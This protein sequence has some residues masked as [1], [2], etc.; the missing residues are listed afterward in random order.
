MKIG[1]Y[2]INAG[3]VLAIAYGFLLACAIGLVVIF[4]T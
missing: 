2:I 4:L 3:C 1:K